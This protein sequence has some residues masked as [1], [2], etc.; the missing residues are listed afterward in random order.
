M[1]RFL[2]LFYAGYAAILTPAFGIVEAYGEDTQ[3]LN[4]ALGFF[5]IRK[6]CSPTAI[7]DIALTKRICSLD[8]IRLHLPYC[9]P[10][11]QRRLYR[12]L[13]PCRHWLP[14]SRR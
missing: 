8:S 5:V 11:N 10:A 2:G 7:F 3:Q 6:N 9:L 4:N 12:H 1:T 13:L 14:D